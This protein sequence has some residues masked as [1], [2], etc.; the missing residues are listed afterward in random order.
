MDGVRLYNHTNYSLLPKLI[1][2][3][4]CIKTKDNLNRINQ[5]NMH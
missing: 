2:I 4:L 1:I 3:Y 5:D